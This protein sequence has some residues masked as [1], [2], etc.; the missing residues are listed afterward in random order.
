VAAQAI[1]SE[2]LTAATLECRD[3]CADSKMGKYEILFLRPE[4]TAADEFDELVND[5][6]ARPHIGYF[7]I[8]RDKFGV[9]ALWSMSLGHTSPP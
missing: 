7:A 6:D 5:A 9:Y 3:I 8:R 4:T 1:N 2:A